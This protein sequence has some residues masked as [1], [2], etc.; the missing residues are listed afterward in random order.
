M[1]ISKRR[2][3]YRESDKIKEKDAY[4]TSS[5]PLIPQAADKRLPSGRHALYLNDSKSLLMLIAILL[6]LLLSN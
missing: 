1:S 3:L 2:K 4:R 6:Q 5:L